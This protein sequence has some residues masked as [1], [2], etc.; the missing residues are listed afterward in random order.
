MHCPQL[1][2]MSEK[3][4]LKPDHLYMS[5]LSIDLSLKITSKI[6]AVLFNPALLF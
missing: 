2:Q 1:K 3:G 4:Y 6:I 5:L